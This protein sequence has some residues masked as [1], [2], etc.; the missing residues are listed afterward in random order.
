VGFRLLAGVAWVTVGL[1][2]LIACVNITGLLVA[3]VAERRREIAV[4]V[5]IGAGRARVVQAMLIESFLL[6]AT[7]VAVGLPLALALNQ[8]PWP[9]A[10]GAMQDAMALD[11][12]V[13][14]F[15]G[16]LVVAATVVCGIVPALKATRSDV[17]SEVRL[18]G[19]GVTPRLWLRQALVVGQVAM[20][21]LLVVASLL[22]VRSQIEVGRTDLGFDLDHGVVVS[23]ALDRSQ[24]PGEARVRFAEPLVD[25]I[26]QVPGVSAV[27][28]A[29][30]VPLSGDSLVRS[31]H[32][33]GRTDIPGTRPSTYSVGPHFFRTLAIPVL[34]GREFMAVD[35]AGTPPVA[36][37]NET[38]ART[39][40][41]NQEVLGQR[42]ATADEADAEVIGLV[43]DHR[44]GTI[45]EAP[46]SVVYYAFAQRPRN[47]ILHVRTATSPDAL[48]NSVRRAVEGAGVAVPFTVQTLGSAT[49]LEMTMRRAGTWLMGTM[50]AIGLLL[51]A[52]GLY[53]VMSHLVASRT[54]EIGIRMA[55]GASAGRIHEEVLRRALRVVAA[56]VGI[57]A[58]LAVGLL[59]VFRTFLAGV[60]PFDPLVFGTA[61]LLLAVVGLGASYVPALRSARLDPIRA[62]RHL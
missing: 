37:V 22:C 47:L 31:F 39:Y 55:L 14:P 61:A 43:R 58:L 44:I 45:G 34:R 21:L 51:A 6:V 38:F 41:P 17:V 11:R 62:L 60:S 16:A 8:I 1:V 33:A 46:Q 50:G 3:R 28:M 19:E 7:G 12:R 36:I 24:Y 27:S 18:G 2:L 57:G 29:S 59:P 48:V 42:V 30:V 5:A 52:I 9:G 23:F 32:P 13:L 56:G 26:E 53:G 10:L 15:S 54:A 35:Q 20:S 25:R 4:R 49:S 40:F